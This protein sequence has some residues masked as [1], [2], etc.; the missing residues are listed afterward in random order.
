MRKI[1]KIV[2]LLFFVFFSCKSNKKTKD[3]NKSLHIS[4]ENKTEL[5]QNFKHLKEN[6]YTDIE[7]IIFMKLS[8]K[9]VLHPATEKTRKDT[10][11]EKYFFLNY[12]SII[13]I[14]NFLNVDKYKTIIPDQV[15]A[16]DNY[17]YTNK[18][19]KPGMRSKTITLKK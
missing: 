9:S 2:I 1:S 13:D 7:G 5:T 16:D 17:I 8:N 14:N 6:L 18:Y 10:I 11:Y 19:Y 15:Y 12:D 3:L 4:L